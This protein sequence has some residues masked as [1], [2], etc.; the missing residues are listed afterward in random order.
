M[1]SARGQNA[2]G[3]GRRT[4][5]ALLVIGGALLLYAAVT[6]KGG[7]PDPTDTPDLGHGAVIMNSALLVTR[8]GLEA[9]LVLAAVTASFRGVNADKVRP[10]H[11]GVGVG[12]LAS[13][14]TWFAAVWVLG[15]LGGS[16][17]DVQA[18]TG[19]V[20][21]AVLLVVMNWF[22]HKVYWTGW[23]SHHHKRRRQL[24]AGG[25]R[26]MVLGLVLLGFTSVYREGFEIV[27][28]LQNLRLQYGGA[29]VLEGV[30][31]GMAFTVAIGV[32]T[33][34]A[35]R[36]LPYKRMLVLTGATI[37]FVLVVMVGESAQE[38]QLAG[39]IPTTQLGFTLPGWM[40]TW[41]A[42]FPTV[43]TLAAQAI[44]GAAVIGS[45][46]LAER[47]AHAPRPQ[48][49]AAPYAPPR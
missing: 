39:W 33:F 24:L 16:G 12:V 13:V 40:G 18:G 44:A 37:A 1:A 4:W 9:I 3:F 23:I 19:L 20:A 42:V 30:A 2:G 15:Q 17:L 38:L 32:L 36:R 26:T 46:V 45:Y 21:V 14:V 35:H 28:F 27:L 41:L 22:F 8:E 47:S 48:P 25:G 31:I 6:A 43:E 49:V 11:V 7:V 34:Y 29:V 5:T 10:V